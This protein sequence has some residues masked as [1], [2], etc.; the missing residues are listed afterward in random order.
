MVS[1]GFAYAGEGGG[2]V[3]VMAIEKKTPP[4]PK[5][6]IE[7]DSATYQ[8][9]IDVGYRYANGEISEWEMAGE[10]R[11]IDS[12]LELFHLNDLVVSVPEC[13]WNQGEPVYFRP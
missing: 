7:V 12:R 10:C 9:L 11:A 8:R 1:A 13:I 2:E 3:N 6:R 4:L 5:K